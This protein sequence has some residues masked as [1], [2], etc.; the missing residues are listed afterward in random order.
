MTTTW[1]PNVRFRAGSVLFDLQ[2]GVLVHGDRSV[3]LPPTQLEVLRVLVGAAPHLVTR[4]ELLDR[5][6]A[7]RVVGDAAL[8]QA[9]KELRQAL[10]DDARRPTFIATVSRRGYRFVASFSGEDVS[11]DAAQQPSEPAPVAAAGAGAAE[12]SASADLRSLARPRPGARG[13]AL[14]VLL[15][16]AASTV[17]VV[18]QRAATRAVGP[19]LA[20]SP[21]RA[22][23]VLGFRNLHPEPES[24]WICAA[25]AELLA[26]E[27]S[28][29]QRLR[30]VP[31]DLV[32]RVLR[33]N[34]VTT[35]G[36]GS[37]IPERIRLSLAA[38]VI[39]TGG[40]VLAGKDGA[41]TLRVDVRAVEAA[42]GEESFTVS[43]S[44]P[45]DELLGLVGRLG[46][47]MRD[48]LGVGALTPAEE[49]ELAAAQP[50]RHDAARLYAE[51]IERMRGYGFAAA[52]VLLERAVAIE[53]DSAGLH[54][55]LARAWS[56]LGYEARET[57]EVQRAFALSGK[58][59]RVD[60]LR[61]EAHL[62][63]R[64]GERARSLEI[65]RALFEF[66]PDDIDIGLDLALALAG[67]GQVDEATATLAA[68]R[69]LPSPVGDDAR[70]DLAEA[71]MADADLERKRAA[72]D[73]AAAKA[74]AGGASLLLAYARIQQGE[75]WRSAGEPAR[76]AAAIFDAINI[77]RAAGDRWGVAKGLTHLG[78][79]QADRG[80]VA[81]AEATLAG[82][83]SEAHEIGSVWS[84]AE[85]LYEL[86]RVQAARDRVAAA[87]ESL[88]HSR[89]LF[90]EIGRTWSLSRTLLAIAGLA[91]DA[92]DVEGAAAVAARVAGECAAAGFRETEAS[93][94]DL[95]ARAALARGDTTA[96]AA[97][98]E[99]ARRAL[100]AAGGGSLQQRLDLDI[101]G[102][103]IGRRSGRIAEALSAAHAAAGQAERA[104]L[105][106]VEL[107]ARV[108]IGAAELADD[109]ER[110]GRATL[111]AVHER[112]RA[113][114]LERLARRAGAVE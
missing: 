9:I 104:G 2:D 71:W 83:A 60:Q 70:I 94:L 27:L 89:A 97:A 42:G 10:G 58:L 22:V 74:E 5:V 21:R 50:R 111:A 95:A 100:A 19:N 3:N 84:E 35:A 65:A 49:S 57:A 109:R 52:A 75:A 39:V 45:P 18:W 103:E 82:A 40:Y 64:L 20:G 91:F 110:D 31:G 28:A 105:L 80:E 44:A 99:R 61:I 107:E 30:V 93:A 8:T 48:R 76:A 47:A 16:A 37:A 66:Y 46:A 72:A 67:A 38:D 78:V 23:A 12:R 68:L 77:R 87:R 17:A 13:I 113:A 56:W 26:T 92:G 79:L 43:A 106:S 69:A 86:G 96:A 108:A 41:R 54:V 33:E 112:A 59:A 15:V 63:E 81:A 101:L 4:G 73:R 53:P 7:D 114:G 62:R 29:G 90:A 25:L 34:A 1:G 32:A 85:A 36:S 102:A 14:A 88:A 55:A 24:A 98:A 51:G 6:W 11:D